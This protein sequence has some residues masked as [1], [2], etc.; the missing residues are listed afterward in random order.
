[1][2]F[3]VSGLSLPSENGA[4]VKGLRRLPFTEE[5]RVRFPYVL[6]N[7][8]ALFRAVFYCNNVGF[9]SILPVYFQG[10]IQLSIFIIYQI[11]PA[12]HGAFNAFVVPPLLNFCMIAT[13]QHIRYFP[14]PEFYRAG[15]NRRCQ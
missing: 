10:N 5:S 3:T 13:H 6:P 4:L 11:W 7:K 14:S 2:E 1:M 15:I 8:T 9:K 12:F